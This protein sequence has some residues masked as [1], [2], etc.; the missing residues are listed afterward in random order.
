LGQAGTGKSSIAGSI[1]AKYRKEN[2]LGSFFH[3]ESHRGFYDFIPTI[4]RDLADRIPIYK[5]RLSQIIQNDTSLRH[6]RNIND[7][8]DKLL[9]EPLA[10]LELPGPILLD[11]DGLDESA[12]CNSSSGNPPRST[13][14]HVLR[15]KL[16]QLPGAFRI[17]MTSRPEVDIT[18][19]FSPPSV[20]ID[21][22][23]MGDVQNTGD[24][25]HRYVSE[26]LSNNGI[27]L[28]G[29]TTGDIQAIVRRSENLFQFAYQCCAHIKRH[30]P[31]SL[32]N[33][34]KK[35]FDQLMLS[36]AT[37]D[38][39]CGLLDD[40]YSLILQSLF[41]GSS[42]D[43][44]G[45]KILSRF[46][47][48]L[49]LIL[50]IQEPLSIDKLSNFHIWDNGSGYDNMLAIIQEMGSLLILK[51]NII[52]LQ[53]SSFRD[54][55]L[56]ESRSRRFYID[57]ADAQRDI[58]AGCLRIMD[59]LHFNFFDFPSS[60]AR[61]KDVQEKLSGLTDE[62]SYACRQWAL[63][64]EASHDRFDI[65]DN[66]GR[67]MKKKFL[68]WLEVLSVLDCIHLVPDMLLSLT[69]ATSVGVC[70]S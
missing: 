50:V 58:L 69:R 10:D 25:I 5:A 57:P 14:L 30:R 64:L 39:Q 4:A 17:F 53:H 26:E 47:A 56:D 38:G 12:K 41:G 36:L 28:D 59:Q 2:L 9:L 46:R 33:S 20:H 45:M 67:F 13:L 51:D 55:L 65:V 34:P 63:H 32:L 40:L 44:E 27:L 70:L 43:S 29:F 49:G 21:V 23:N 3:F 8:F 22:I 7:Q 24:D 66:W 16:P 6:S 11:F 48:V 19:I 68:Y 61:N 35:R 31:G 15:N 62:L 52:N 18:E 37:A 42:A 60:Y 54:F 1:A